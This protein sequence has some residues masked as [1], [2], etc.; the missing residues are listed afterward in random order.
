MCPAHARRGHAWTAEAV[1]G[2]GG[3]DD[4]PPQTRSRT[5]GTQGRA[6]GRAGSGGQRYGDRRLDFGGWAQGAL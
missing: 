6:G 2:L 3:A 1:G 5:V 4:E